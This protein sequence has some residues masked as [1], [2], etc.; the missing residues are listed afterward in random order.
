M[1]RTKDPRPEFVES[2][3]PHRE[4]FDIGHSVMEYHCMA[5]DAGVGERHVLNTTIHLGLRRQAKMG[6]GAGN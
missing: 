6:K 2:I 4:K 1:L 5:V 3:P